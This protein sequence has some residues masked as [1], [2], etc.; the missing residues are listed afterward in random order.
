VLDHPQAV[1]N[2][3]PLAKLGNCS[4]MVAS[5]HSKKLWVI[6][7]HVGIVAMSHTLMMLASQSHAWRQAWMKLPKVSHA[8]KAVLRTLARVSHV[9]KG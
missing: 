1:E 5:T 3:L 8:A 2:M 9:Q 7:N 4:V 6:A